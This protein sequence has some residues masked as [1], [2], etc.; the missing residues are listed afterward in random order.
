MPTLMTPYF[1]PVKTLMIVFCDPLKTS[2]LFRMLCFSS[3]PFLPP[4]LLTCH[5]AHPIQVLPTSI[6]K[7]LRRKGILVVEPED[8]DIQEVQLAHSKP[9][10]R[11]PRAYPKGIA[12]TGQLYEDPKSVCLLIASEFISLSRKEWLR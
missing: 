12:N 10:I 8:A 4:P 6:L 7:L 11:P 2:Q 3:P 1:D 9:W 5:A